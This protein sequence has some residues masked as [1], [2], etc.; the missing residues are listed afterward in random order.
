[1]RELVELGAKAT[2]AT[3]VEDEGQS[4]VVIGFN[5][6]KLSDLLSL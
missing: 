4:T 5:Q 6:E 1:M 3:I 2:P